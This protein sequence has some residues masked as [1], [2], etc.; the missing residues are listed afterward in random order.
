MSSSEHAQFDSF[1]LDAVDLMKAL[2][3]EQSYWKSCCLVVVSNVA[4]QAHRKDDAEQLKSKTAIINTCMVLE[5][6]VQVV[7]FQKFLILDT[8]PEQ[9]TVNAQEPLI[10]TW[11]YKMVVSMEAAIFSCQCD[12]M[13]NC[14]GS[15]ETIYYDNIW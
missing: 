1:W 15:C 6:I 13:Q 4:T 8:C 5:P 14:E 10:S 7:K 2:M 9:L 12:P 11:L 3:K